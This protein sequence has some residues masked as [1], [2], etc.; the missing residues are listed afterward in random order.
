M[1]SSSEWKC[2]GC[3]MESPSKIKRCDCAT[4]CVYRKDGKPKTSAFFRGCKHHPD[5]TIRENL[6]GDDLCQECCVA[7]AKG[8]GEPND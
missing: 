5:R 3:G 2:A 8:E 4:S 6:D 7:W 1:K